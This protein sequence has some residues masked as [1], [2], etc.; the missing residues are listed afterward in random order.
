MDTTFYFR[1]TKCFY[2]PLIERI[3]N[4]ASQR[5]MNKKQN[6]ERIFTIID[7]IFY[8]YS[9]KQQ[10]TIIIIIINQKYI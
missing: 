10:T 1:L 8:T 6:E 2:Q 4:S 5:G 9:I 7:L 3:R